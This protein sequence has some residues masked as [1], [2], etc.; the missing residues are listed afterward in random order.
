[1]LVPVLTTRTSARIPL[2]LEVSLR[3]RN[4]FGLLGVDD[5]DGD[6]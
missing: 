4:L 6:C 1:M 5:S 3:E 2:D